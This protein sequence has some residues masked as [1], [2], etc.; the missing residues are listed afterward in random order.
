[1]AGTFL[2]IGDTQAM[3]P[4]GIPT[5]PLGTKNTAINGKVMGG[6]CTLGRPGS[7]QTSTSTIPSFSPLL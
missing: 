4:V 2:Y 6:V 3:M 1:M 7:G 5:Y